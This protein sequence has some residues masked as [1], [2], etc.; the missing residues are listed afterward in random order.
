MGRGQAGGAPAA[1]PRHVGPSHLHVLPPLLQLYGLAIVQRHGGLVL[2]RCGLLCCLFGSAGR[3]LD[4]AG[5]TGARARMLGGCTRQRA[6]GGAALRRAGDAIKEF[7]GDFETYG[8]ARGLR[9]RG[10]TADR[11]WR[12]PGRRGAQPALPAMPCCARSEL[13]LCC[14]IARQKTA[15]KHCIRGALLPE[16][17][18]GPTTQLPPA[19]AGLRCRSGAAALCPA[20]CYLHGQL[21]RQWGTAGRWQCIHSMLTR[22]A[23]AHALAGAAAGAAQPASDS[24]QP[25]G[26]HRPVA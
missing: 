2:R 22:P 17:F 24:S 16:P 25:T 11:R 15:S 20:Q 1:G 10:G 4:D 21:M 26:C 3:Q 7:G 12:P 14:C 8:R 6:P 13:K 19:A 18:N 9:S 5:S 23:P